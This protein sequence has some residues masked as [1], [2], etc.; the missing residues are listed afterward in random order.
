MRRVNPT[1][2]RL[3]LLGDADPLIELHLELLF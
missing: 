2:H 3:E 1:E